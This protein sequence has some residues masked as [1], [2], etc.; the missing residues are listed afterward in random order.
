MQLLGCVKIDPA[1]AATWHEDVPKNYPGST[2]QEKLSRW[3]TVKQLQNTWQAFADWF[4]GHLAGVSRIV[5]ASQVLTQH[6]QSH[7]SVM[8]DLPA[9]QCGLFPM[10]T[11]GSWWACAPHSLCGRQWVTG[12]MDQ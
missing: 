1:A 7:N 3:T 8:Q 4:P 10:H 6:S 12:G 11:P 5:R 2:R 9:V